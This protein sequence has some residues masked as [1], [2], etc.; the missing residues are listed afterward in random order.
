LLC[1][2]ESPDRV[3]L[4]GD[5][6]GDRQLHGVNHFALRILNRAEWEATVK[7]ENLP[8]QYGGAYPYPH[9]TSWYINDP[10]GYEI[11]VVLW[12]KDRITF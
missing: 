10:T 9:S 11:E 5:Q 3:F 8:V 12:E 6:L 7:A 4:D 1:L 2:Y